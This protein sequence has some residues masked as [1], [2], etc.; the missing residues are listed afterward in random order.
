MCIY[1]IP[2]IKIADTGYIS[3]FS[4]TFDHLNISLAELLSELPLHFVPVRFYDILEILSQNAHD[5][6]IMTE[7]VRDH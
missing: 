2:P 4:Q 6:R 3:R 1:N 5:R 7:F